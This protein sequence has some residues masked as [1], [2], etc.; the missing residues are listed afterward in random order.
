MS[1]ALTAPA[2]VRVFAPCHQKHLRHNLR[3]PEQKSLG[4]FMISCTKKSQSPPNYTPQNCAFVVKNPDDMISRISDMDIGN[5]KS[6]IGNHFT[7]I[8]WQRFGITTCR[9]PH[10]PI[11]L[12]C[13]LRKF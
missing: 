12:K 1:I 3:V 10:L 6:E 4:P 13:F 2:T 7:S 5:R 11:N 9:H 8:V